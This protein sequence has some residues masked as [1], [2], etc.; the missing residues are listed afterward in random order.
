MDSL[1]NLLFSAGNHKKCKTGNFRP[2][3]AEVVGYYFSI[4]ASLPRSSLPTTRT[5]LVKSHD[6]E[7][8]IKASCR[9]RCKTWVSSEATCAVI[10][11]KLRFSSSSV[12][13]SSH[14]SCSSFL[15]CAANTKTLCL[16]S[17]TASTAAANALRFTSPLIPGCANPSAAFIV[18]QAGP[19]PSTCIP[20]SLTIVH[21][22]QKVLG[23][24][25]DGLRHYGGA[26]SALLQR[27]PWTWSAPNR[28]RGAE[29]P[30]H[31]HQSIAH[32]RQDLE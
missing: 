5:G 23:S 12:T 28:N 31:T 24:V 27:E 22:S 14:F 32:H 15:T 1:N 13:R 4:L 30:R 3:T 10:A 6:V 19:L 9:S 2:S 26:Q 17:A 18:L 8:N 20:S 11:C 16:A 25:L 29:L 21:P 7:S